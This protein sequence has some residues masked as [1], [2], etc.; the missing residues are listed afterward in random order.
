MYEPYRFGLSL[1]MYIHLLCYVSFRPAPQR[2]DAINRLIGVLSQWHRPPPPPQRAPLPPLPPL[3][4]QLLKTAPQHHRQ[5]LI[6]RLLLAAALKAAV[7]ACRPAMMVACRRSS[8][9]KSQTWRR[10]RTRQVSQM[11]TFVDINSNSYQ[12]TS[13]TVC[14]YGLSM[15][16]SCKIQSVLFLE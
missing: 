15:V 1:Y 7:A 12:L 14:C 4:P 16:V 6:R 13:P 2:V 5:L 9:P 8:T 10:I 3:P 11:R